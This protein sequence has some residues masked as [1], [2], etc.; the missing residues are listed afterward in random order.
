M[1]RHVIDKSGAKKNL[2]NQHKHT[3]PYTS[4]LARMLS[5]DALKNTNY[6]N[7]HLR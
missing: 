7:I 3:H 6:I 5:N 4:A 2:L 1:Q